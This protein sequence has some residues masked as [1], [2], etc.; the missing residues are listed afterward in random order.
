MSSLKQL[1]P[2]QRL[3]GHQIRHLNTLAAMIAGIVQSQSCH[4]EKMSG[5]VPDQ[6]QVASRAKRFARFVQHDGINQGLFF[7]PF[8]KPLVHALA[9]RG[10]LTLAMDGSEVG[11][12][13]IALMVSV[14]YRKRALPLAWVVRQGS[15]G[16]WPEEAHLQLL[17][18]VQ[19][20]L[21]TDCAAVFLGD[22]EFDGLQLQAAITAA[23]W[24]Y[25]CRTARNSIVIDDGDEFALSELALAPGECIDM[26]DVRFTRAAYGPVLLIA[27]QRSGYNEPLYLVSNMVC[28]GEACAWYQRRFRIETFFSDQKSRGF[29]LHKSH[30]SAPER[31]QRLLLATCLAYIWIIYLGVQARSDPNTLRQIHRGD[32]CDLSLF[33]L[34]LRYLNHLLCQG[35]RLPFSLV[36]PC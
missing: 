30:I 24:E 5:K 21:P 32:R 33:Q 15:K 18:E 4:L 26:P 12:E 23:G 9:S 13:C 11:R 28:V 16:H 31:L 8:V 35:S 36:L 2:S 22:G 7:M 19:T 20:L 17:D 34:G 27:W 10:R 29:N 3:N 6:T 25:V 1:Y 14:I